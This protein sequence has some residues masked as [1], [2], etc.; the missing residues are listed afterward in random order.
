[1]AE[2]PIVKHLKIEKLFGYNDIN[3]NFNAVTVIVGKNGMGKTTLLKILQC[4]LSDK[5]DT[6]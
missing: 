1:M 3:I 5:A 6:S 2:L 4:L